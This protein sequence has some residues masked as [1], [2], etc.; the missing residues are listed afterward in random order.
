MD[1]VHRAC[2]ER[3]AAFREWSGRRRLGYL[4]VT[5]C[6]GRSPLGR[7]TPNFQVHD[8]PFPLPPSYI[9]LPSKS[10]RAERDLIQQQQ[11]ITF[12][13]F[14]QKTPLK[15]MLLFFVSVVVGLKP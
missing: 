2:G 6:T 4:S 13:L 1:V 9:T 12:V 8:C 10:E 3:R 5:L 14:I 7:A 15:K 11:K